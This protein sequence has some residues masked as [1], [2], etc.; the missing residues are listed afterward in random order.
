MVKS[1]PSVLGSFPITMA[2]QLVASRS[3]EGLLW[4]RSLRGF[5]AQGKEGETEL[6]L[7][8]AHIWTGYEEE[9][10]ECWCLVG[11]LPFSYLAQ[12]PRPRVVLATFMVH[13]SSLAKTL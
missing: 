3:R 13:L 12:W 2:R 10:T 6:M 5:N 7:A 11:F 8:D 4:A 1:F 9:S